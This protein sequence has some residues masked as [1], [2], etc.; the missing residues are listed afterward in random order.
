MTTVS[1]QERS[2]GIEAYASEGLPCT[3]RLRSGVDDF[4]VEEY[5]ARDLI[6]K[7]ARPS[8][9][10]VY[11]VEKRS[12]DT[13]HLERELSG[14]LRSRVAYG[15]LKDKR[16]VAVQ[17][18]TPTSLNSERPESIERE[19]FSAKLVGYLPRPMSSGLVVGNRFNITV[20]ECCPD[21][22]PRVEEVFGLGEQRRLPNFFGLQRFGRV[23]GGTHVLGRS[24]VKRE[25][26]EAVRQMLCVARANDDE[27]TR[28]AREAMAWGRYEE[29]LRLLPLRQDMERLV[30]GRLVRD[31]EGWVGALRALPVRLRRLFVQ[32]YQSF[33]FNRTISLAVARGV[34]FSRYEGGDNWSEARADGL[35][36]GPV[37]GVKDGGMEGAL[38]MVQLA[39][40][41]YRDYG[42][43]FDGL[44]REV[45]DE[46][47]VSARDFYIQEMQEAS[48]EGGFRVPHL[49]VRD[50]SCRVNERAAE[51]GF[52]LARGQFAT[53]LLREVIKPRD[54]TESGFA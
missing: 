27:R 24:M 29:G 48:A 51:L 28:A 45:M 33:I 23:E 46:E 7:E 50:S 1:E 4:R 2:V 11:R 20:R 37:H 49:L 43:R 16:A 31:P 13:M 39:G 8:Y 32:A 22:G 12:I 34:D 25:F 36:M 9:F 14:L 3:A 53:V 18:V 35:T 6:S 54:P 30:A 38:P 40:Y 44:V 15:G 19:K 5:I 41:A 47:A 42:S 21:I 10:P 26:A 17:Y 52:T